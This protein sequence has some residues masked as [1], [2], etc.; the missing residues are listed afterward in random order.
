ML[1][2]YTSTKGKYQLDWTAHHIVLIHSLEKILVMIV[3]N[4]FVL[5]LSYLNVQNK[6]AFTQFSQLNK[7]FNQLSLLNKDSKSFTMTKT[8]INN[9]NNK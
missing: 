9:G 5:S 8:L 4:R 6:Y 1:D 3:D 7:I 2:D